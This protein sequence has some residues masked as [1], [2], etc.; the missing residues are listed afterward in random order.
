M[1]KHVRFLGPLMKSLPMDW[2]E[3]TGD[4]RT[5]AFFGFLKTVARINNEVGTITGAAFETAA[6]PIRTILY[7]LYSD[8]EMLRNLRA[9]LANA[10]RGEDGEFSIAVL[11]KLLFLDGVIRE[12]LRLSPG[13]ATRLARVASDRDLYYDQ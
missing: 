1:T 11:E 13:L 7:H 5:K 8:R 10:H 6:Q 2:I 12:E 4:A 9:E 3:K